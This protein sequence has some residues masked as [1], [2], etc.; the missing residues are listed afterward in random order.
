MLLYANRGLPELNLT[1]IDPLQLGPLVFSTGGLNILAKTTTI[2]GGSDFQIKKIKM[3]NFA[4]KYRLRFSV[5][6]IF[7]RGQYKVEGNYFL[8]FFNFTGGCTA[9]LSIYETFP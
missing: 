6:R 7:V 9:N 1:S 2:Y 3:V 8:F 4:K 5:P